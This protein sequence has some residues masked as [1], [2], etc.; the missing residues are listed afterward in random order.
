METATLIPLPWAII[1][2][3]SQGERFRIALTADE[4]DARR[5]AATLQRASAQ[6]GRRYTVEHTE[7]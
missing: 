3:A 1:E 7:G 5:M 2:V 6:T 4:A